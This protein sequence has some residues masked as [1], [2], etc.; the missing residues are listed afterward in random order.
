MRVERQALVLLVNLVPK[1]GLLFRAGAALM[2]SAL[3]MPVTA[4][5]QT[6][7]LGVTLAQ[8]SLRYQPAEFIDPADGLAHGA[9]RAIVQDQYGLVW[10]GTEGGLQRYDG[11]VFE[12]FTASPDSRLRLADSRVQALA[13][14]KDGSLW[15]GTAAGLDVIDAQRGSVRE[16]LGPTG[17]Q[18]TVL[19]MS[20]SLE[21]GLLVGSNRQGLLRARKA[22]SGWALDPFGPRELEGERFLH[23]R[24]AEGILVFAPDSLFL[25]D[26]DGSIVE[27]RQVQSPMVETFTRA[28]GVIDRQFEPHVF[29][30]SELPV[31]DA[32]H[33]VMTSQ[34]VESSG[35]VHPG[36]WIGTI[37]G[38]FYRDREHGGVERR[39]LTRRASAEG[40]PVEEAP[41]GL[42]QEVLSLMQ[43]RDGAVWVGTYGGLLKID[44]RRY[45]FDTLYDEVGRPFDAQV[46]SLV[47]QDGVLWV[48]TF[49]AGVFAFDAESSE[50]RRRVSIEAGSDEQCSDYVWSLAVHPGGGVVV[51]TSGG[52]CLVTEAG[53]VSLAFDEPPNARSLLVDERGRLWVGAVSGVFRVESDE[54]RLVASI[55]SG[56]LLQLSSEKLL[57]VPATDILAN[58]S[59]LHVL[60]TESGAVSAIELP[61]GLVIYDVALADAEGVR[62]WLGA[63]S[64]LLLLDQELGTVEE[65]QLPTYDGLAITAVF[66][67]SEPTDGELWLGTNRGLVRIRHDQTQ[68]FEMDAF[69]TAE[70]VASVEFNRRAQHLFATGGSARRLAVGG[71]TGVALF[72]PAEVDGQ[73]LQ[74]SPIILRSTVDGDSG[75]R[76]DE[77][78]T[79][80]VMNRF[81]RV[82]TFGF[83]AASYTRASQNRFRYRFLDVDEDWIETR[84]RRSSRYVGLLP[85]EY[86]FEVMAANGSG[87]WSDSPARLSVR[88]VPPFWV[89]WWFRLA[90]V[91]ALL[92]LAAVFYQRRIARLL[93]LERMR[94]RIAT[95]LHDELGSEL[96]G[97]AFASSVVGRSS[98]VGELER[99]RLAEIA[100]TARGVM[101]GLRDIVWYVNPEHDEV[102]SLVDR[103]RSTARRL[104][105]D[106]RLDFAAAT[107]QEG[108]PLPL[109]MNQRR[110]V[111]LIFKELVT[112]A[113]KHSGGKNLVVRIVLEDTSLG[114]EVCDDGVGFGERSRDGTGL[115]SVHRRALEIGAAIDVRERAEGGTRFVLTVPLRRG[116][117]RANDKNVS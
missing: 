49:G 92:G 69:G 51:G 32:I 80:L 44:P 85:G 12:S 55:R 111:H 93:E 108:R 107:G 100:E 50:L 1:Q 54:A 18:V 45:P 110:Q 87:S 94:L 37:G 47:E 84:S 9:V 4:A 101:E 25:L 11:S 67:I 116:G 61:E 31:R 97:I 66:S 89:T 77:H 82:V 53:L 23:R 71:M 59:A 65:V 95:D 72:N 46:S 83:T 58:T 78:P 96:S 64:G 88:V 102:N 26:N 98:G 10:L 17:G 7:R 29:S 117:S 48:G 103:M 74:P 43:D 40:V 24:V 22:S 38:L 70:G 34:L 114:L 14:S 99:K 91:L 41:F 57:V 68:V 112:N 79:R 3:A 30:G 21:H 39:V 62:L 73:A 15:V 52:V 86:T 81:D 75:A 33:H 8:T 6:T 35:A 109:D 56:K 115:R 20:F 106:L 5:T 28:G 60:D 2:L 63:G 113:A 104:A 105:P 36:T 16:V 90:C 13:L 76:I 42:E 27:R 19:Q